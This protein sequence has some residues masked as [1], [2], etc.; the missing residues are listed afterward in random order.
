MTIRIF[1]KFQQKKNVLFSPYWIFKNKSLFIKRSL[2]WSVFDK[3]TSQEKNIYFCW[4]FQEILMVT[5][6]I[7]GQSF[8]LK[9]FHSIFSKYLVM[10]RKFSK[11]GITLHQWTI[12]P[13]PST[14]FLIWIYST[15]WGMH[16][17]KQ[18]WITGILPSSVRQNK[19]QKTS[20]GSAWFNFGRCAKDLKNE[21]LQTLGL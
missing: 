16:K 5:R 10:G 1:W 14:H 13:N 2:K 15:E 4:K 20:L 9:F 21:C 19:F 11:M 8:G 18:C 6:P 12:S 3:S 7:Y 17:S